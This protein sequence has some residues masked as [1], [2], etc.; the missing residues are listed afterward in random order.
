MV[1]LKTRTK[2]KMILITEISLQLTSNV[3]IT[4]SG[5]VGVLLSRWTLVY[6]AAVPVDIVR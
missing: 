1:D 5:G 4:Y 3:Q 6:I 2:S